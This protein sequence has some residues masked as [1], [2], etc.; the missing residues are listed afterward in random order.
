[1]KT[2][3]LLISVLLFA[4]IIAAFAVMNVEPVRIQYAFGEAQIPLILV[5]LGSALLGGLTVGFFG[6][7]KQYK[8]QRRIR[9][10]TTQ[11]NQQKPLEDSGDSV[12][13]ETVQQ[14]TLIEK[15]QG[16]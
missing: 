3:W 13:K 15:K 11:L 1:M 4:L 5:I 10:L 7:V 2:Q 16:E 12:P 9:E 6:I 8:L 14:G